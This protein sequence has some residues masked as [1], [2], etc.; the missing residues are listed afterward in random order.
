M[1][2]GLDVSELPS[3]GF[4]HRSLMWWGT[5]GLIVIESCVF[6]YAV[7]AWFY[8]RGQTQLWPPTGEP[9]DWRW[10]LATTLWLVL[11]LAPNQRVKA[12]AE[13]LELARVKPLL[14]VMSL[15]SAGVLAL[16]VGEFQH[17]NVTWESSAYGSI[18]WLILGLHT[19]HLVTDAWDTWVLTVLMH[20]GPLEGKRFGDVSENAMYWIFVVVSWVPIAA[21]LYLGPQVW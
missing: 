5:I 13:R 17:L 16:R 15:L 12:A 21:V 18:V 3:F 11:S 7:A 14:I 2:R 1:S 6:A 19:V 20:T 8:L 9:P 4:S 10:G